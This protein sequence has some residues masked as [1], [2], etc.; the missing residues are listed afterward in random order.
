[1][2]FRTPKRFYHGI[3][4]LFFSEK[5]FSDGTVCIEN[6]K[7]TKDFSHRNTNYQV[8]NNTKIRIINEKVNLQFI[9]LGYLGT[10]KIYLPRTIE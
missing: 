3:R 8:V 1:M 4:T 9:H 10:K 5:R 7:R 2:V 6:Y